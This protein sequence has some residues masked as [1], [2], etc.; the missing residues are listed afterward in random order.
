MIDLGLSRAAQKALVRTLAAD[1]LVDVQ[2]G[3]LDMEHRWLSSLNGRITGGQVNIDADADVTRQLQLTFVDEQRRM[4]VDTPDG[5]PELRRMIRV[6]YR[7]LVE[8]VVGDW[9]SIPVFTGPITRVSRDGE[10]V[11]LEAMG[12]E[13]LILGPTWRS[14]VYQKGSN[15]VAVVRSILRDLTGERRIRFPKGWRYRTSKVITMKKDSSAWEQVQSLA[16]GMRVQLFYDGRGFARMRRR[17]VRTSFTFTDGDGGTLLST[18]KVSES[19][20]DVV[21]LVRVVGAVP[22]G[23]KNPLVF[24]DK[25]PGS[26]PHS[27]QQMGRHGEPRYLPEQIDDDSLRTQKEVEDAARRRLQEIKL[28]EQLVTFDCLPMPLLEEGD[29]FT[30]DAK[31]VKVTGRVSQMVIPL[32]HEGRSTLGYLA[33]ASKR[34]R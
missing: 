30:I 5:R 34:R 7:V 29:L 21:N 32:G 20:Q 2:V 3:V 24:T 19:S 12:K 33:P 13:H 23:K 15:R 22:T 9:V 10:V 1:H 11:T 28:D 6:R 27:P 18:P 16:R 25:L 14:K 17:P 31:D 26:H 4:R 8:D